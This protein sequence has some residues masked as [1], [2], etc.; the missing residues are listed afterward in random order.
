MKTPLVSLNAIDRA[1]AVFSPQRALERAQARFHLGALTRASYDGARTDW[2][3]TSWRNEASGPIA[4]LYGDL[5][6][7]RN[8]A[9]S[10]VR[11]TPIAKKGM[12]ALVSHSVGTGIRP[13]F[14]TSSKAQRARLKAAWDRFVETAD[15]R[16]QTTLYGIQEQ[17]VRSMFESG[18]ALALRDIRRRSGRPVLSYLVVEGDYL[19]HN[20][21][22]V[23]NK[24]GGTA[25]GLLTRLG[26]TFEKGGHCRAGYWLFENN[27][28]DSLL[29]GAKLLSKFVPADGVLHLYRVRRPGS[30]RGVSELAAAMPIIRDLADYRESALVKARVEAA[31]VGVVTSEQTGNLGLASRSEIKSA[32]DGS[33]QEVTY[34]ELVPG[35]MTRLPAGDKVTFSQPS[36]NPNFE[37][38]VV[39]AAMDAAAG[40]GATYDQVT[41]D[42]RQANY[43]S[44]RAG[45][46]EFRRTVEMIQHLTIIPMICAPM[47]REFRNF[48]RTFDLLQEK[49]LEVPARWIT[50]AWEPIDPLKDLQADILAV[51]SGRMSLEDYI[52]SWGEDP[53]D[54]LE[55]I[56]R[57]NAEVDRLGIVL[58]TDPRHV[59]AAG[60]KH[61]DGAAQGSSSSSSKSKD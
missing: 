54:Q 30:V 51:R 34:S 13:S 21:E 55:E 31:F 60:L 58:D 20:R 48:A 4:G 32:T 52:A 43:S 42:L 40:M 15:A 16:G 41:G 26:V 23:F 33:S 46:I 19:D 47:L 22:G 61:N 57:V 50:P 56:A 39:Q 35:T 29:W 49:D 28:N 18:E 24:D 45:K 7:L 3:G 2:R 14:K 8:R 12:E 36:V 27:P 53:T 5:V 1:I 10:L 44:L 38:F 17:A 11:N 6:T 9:R 59:T 37:P 25:D